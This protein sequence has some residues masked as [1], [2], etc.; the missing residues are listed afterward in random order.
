MKRPEF[1]ESRVIATL[2]L[3]IFAASSQIMIIAP[4]LPSIGRQL[5]MPESLQGLL[6]TSYAVMVGVV[7]LVAGPVSDRIG[8]R[9]IMLFGTISLAVAL[10]LH[11]LVTDYMQL[12]A[13]RALAGVAGG[14]LSGSVVSYVGDTFPPERRGWA[15]GWIM[16]GNAT[17]QILG[18]PLGT[19][20]AE[21]FGFRI[22]FLMFG[23]F[24]VVAWRMV[25]H[26]LPQ[27][28][29][30]RDT[31]P[32]ALMPVLRKYKSLLRDSGIRNALAAYFLMF[33]SV[34][35]FITYF[36]TWLIFRHG[37]DGTFVASI[38]FIGGIA[39][40]ITGPRMGRLS[41]RIGRRKLVMVS[42]LGTSVLVAGTTLFI[43]HPLLAYPLF[44]GVMVLV[45]MRVSPF[46]AL[47]SSLTGDDR[48]GTLM[49]LSAAL[50]QAGLGLGGAV[51]A[52][53]YAG[54]GYANTTFMAAAAILGTGWLVW[55]HVP[56]PGR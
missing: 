10:L 22:P 50:G 54:L 53:T 20:L 41:D 18:I 13:A 34:G 56:E 44:F 8:R 43:V 52:L 31:G 6:V 15:N 51:S 32:L 29:V 46:Q 38:F 30:E 1:R 25:V 45:A 3:L 16:S 2:W 5:A 9:R 14:I 40:V 23:L 27:P 47:L 24:M 11:G 12:I 28:A 4:L 26:F 42:A 48:R 37:V 21:W 19:L 7:A 17:G 33:V 36:P 55:K 35:G 39:N 49:S